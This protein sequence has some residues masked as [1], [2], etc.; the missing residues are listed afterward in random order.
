M[1]T[2]GHGPSTPYT[3]TG[4]NRSTGTSATSIATC[5]I[6]IGARGS[7]STT[8]AIISTSHEE[9]GRRSTRVDA[10]ISGSSL[11][12]RRLRQLSHSSSGSS[13]APRIA[14]RRWNVSVA[15]LYSFRNRCSTFRP[16]C[17]DSSASD[18]ACGAFHS[19]HIGGESICARRRSL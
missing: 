19:S 5:S 10:W 7:N 12:M 18:D 2:Y 13:S 9:I 16:F 11:S 6:R 15:S 8:L 4:S 1:A 3:A 17:I 14:L